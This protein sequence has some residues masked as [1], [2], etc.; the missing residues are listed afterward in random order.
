M[1]YRLDK[2]GIDLRFDVN[3]IV[4]EIQIDNTIKETTISAINVNLFFD[5][6]I[7][8]LRGSV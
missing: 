4:Y 1:N 6:F 7:N 2:Y 8:G 5:F 3:Q